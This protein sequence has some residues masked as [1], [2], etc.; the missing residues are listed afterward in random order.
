MTENFPDASGQ[1][2]KIGYLVPQFPG[3]THIFFWREVIELEKRGVELAL[4]STTPPPKGLISHDWS[5][6]AMARTDYLGRADIAALLWTLPRAP[7][8][9]IAREIRREG[10]GFARDV[11]ICLPAARRLIRACRTQGIGHVHAHSCGRAALIAALAQRMGGP[12]YSL[13]LHGP[14]SDYGPGQRFKWR[15]AR[16]ATIITEKLLAEVRRDLAGDLPPALPVQAMGVDVDT[17]AP[18][19]PYRPVAKGD[20]LRIFA[21]GRLHVVKG[22]QDLMQAVRLLRDRGVDVQLEIAGEDDHGGSG[23]HGALQARLEELNLQDNVRLLG[24]VSA[25]RVRQGIIDAHAFVLASWHE[26]LGVAYMEAMACGTPTI[27]TDAGGVPEL[28]RDGIDGLLVPPKDPEALADALM[29]LAGD[30]ALALRLSG[31]GRTRIV[32]HFSAARGAETL[33]AHWP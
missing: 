12:S 16:F 26:P 5:D 10:R 9:E 30:P 33:M 15:G 8:S 20:P 24:A 18:D 27:G 22:H 14:M 4:F 2:R 23:Y 31:N 29:R 3:Q 21:C 19:G 7:W 11:L 17:F 25:E 32:E 13:T 6:T 28:I 1:A